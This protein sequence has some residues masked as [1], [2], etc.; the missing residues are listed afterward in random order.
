MLQMIYQCT[1]D[2][3]SLV[4]PLHHVS[5]HS[6]QHAVKTLW[7]ATNIASGPVF[8][9]QLSQGQVSQAHWLGDL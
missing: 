5:R 4:S 9:L 6:L 1:G 7:S 2:Q 3:G 8:T